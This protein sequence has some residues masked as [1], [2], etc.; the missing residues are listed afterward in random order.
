MTYIDLILLAIVF[1]I[2]YVSIRNGFFK[3]L[4]N[5][6]AY[7]LAVVAAK[8]VS[9]IFA[10]ATFDRFI[11]SGAE[12]YLSES[13]SDITVEQLPEQA[14]LVIDSVPD[15]LRGLLEIIGFSKEKISEQI[16]S[17]ELESQ[18]IV[19]S[20]V[21]NVVEPIGTAIMQFLIFIILGIVFLIVAKIIVRLLDGVIKKLPV[22]KG[23]NSILGGALGFIRG[24]LFAVVFA[25][26]LGII[27]S[28]SDNQAFIDAVSGSVIMNLLTESIGGFSF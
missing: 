21:D 12:E 4:F 7:V 18:D 11:R 13:L 15:K 3:T 5:L 20:V 28:V 9:P 1:V 8:V 19:T 17:V 14:E 26:V 22:V 6:L 2:V 24:L 27:A 16:E 25:G 23:V 10:R